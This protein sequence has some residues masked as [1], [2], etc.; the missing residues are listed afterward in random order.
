[1]GPENRLPKRRL[2]LPADSSASPV[3]QKEKGSSSSGA[4]AYVAEEDTDALDCGVCFLPL[5]PPIF[6]CE[7]G[8]LLCSP[9][10]DRL[11]AAGKC[12][13]C[14]IATAGGYRRCHGMERLVESVRVSCP[15]AVHGC[16][17]R[18]AYYEQHGHRQTCAHAPCHCPAEGCDFVGSTAALW[19]HFS[20]VHGWPCTPQVLN[21]TKKGATSMLYRM[22]G[23][24]SVSL[25]D[26][27]NF[28]LFDRHTNDDHGVVTCTNY[29]FLLNV[30]RQPNGR[31]IS[32]FWIHP[33]AGASC[34]YGQGSS[35]KLKFELSYS[36]SAQVTADQ[37]IANHSQ[38]SEFVV[39]CTDLSDGLPSPDGCF[40]FLVLDSVIADRDRVSISITTRVVF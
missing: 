29:L 37:L 33:N 31:A 24:A 9:C 39:V 6:Q 32:V 10:R 1:M 2:V 4:A 28:L 26:G 22:F 35:K 8:H 5:K 13:V 38:K 18:P 23:H 16:T 34:G 30:V 7:V 25:R 40:Q 21:D 36:W 19:D 12:H 17:A 20:G 27:F 11:A 15:Y 14:G 3:V